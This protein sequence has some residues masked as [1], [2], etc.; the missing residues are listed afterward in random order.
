MTIVTIVMEL[1]EVLIT[2][3]VAGDDLLVALLPSIVKLARHQVKQGEAEE[4]DQKNDDDSFI[5][6]KL[7]ST[8]DPSSYP[9]DSTTGGMN[10]SISAQP[11][12]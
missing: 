7:S 6:C 12:V 4:Y 2:D 3:Q 10:R 8:D 1:L 9:C 11:S 5:L